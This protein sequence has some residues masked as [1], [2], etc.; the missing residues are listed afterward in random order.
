M[1]EK[2]VPNVASISIHEHDAVEKKNPWSP[3]ILAR[4]PWLGLLGMVGAIA[5]IAVGVVILVLSND[6]PIQDWSVQPSV[7]L[8]IISAA[9]GILFRVGFT[10]ALNVVWWRR[11]MKENTTIAEL[12]QNWEYGSSLFAA[13]TSGKNVNLIAL[14]AILAALVPVQAPLFQ[15]ASTVQSRRYTEM[16]DLKVNIA[17][18]IPDGQVP[19]YLILRGYIR[20]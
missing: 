16:R 14:A 4:A 5:V 10:S 20:S 11:A 6:K 13:V 8:S 12:H 17:K 7:Y 2:T 15:K 19:S 9:A 18:T 1:T 3:G